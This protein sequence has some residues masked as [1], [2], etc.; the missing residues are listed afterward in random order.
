MAVKQDAA[1]LMMTPSQRIEVDGIINHSLLLLCVKIEFGN[2]CECRGE[3]GSKSKSGREARRQARA[4][5]FSPT[6]LQPRTDGNRP[7]SR[8]GTFARKPLNLIHK[9]KSN[10]QAEFH[11]Q[12][13][14]QS[15]FTPASLISIPLSAPPNPTFT[16]TNH[17]AQCP[18]S[19]C[20]TRARAPTARVAEPGTS[21]GFPYP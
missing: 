19:R 18:T 11:L 5:N 8:L 17:H 3:V 16:S 9:P 20:G 2:P 12:L 7:I 15:P 14:H 13:L 4:A 10:L 21:R 6:G 1:S